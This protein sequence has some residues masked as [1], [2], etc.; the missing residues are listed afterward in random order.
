MPSGQ[1]ETFRSSLSCSVVA[2][3]STGRQTAIN[4]EWQLTSILYLHRVCTK[5]VMFNERKCIIPLQL[6]CGMRLNY[7]LLFPCK[8][9]V[10]G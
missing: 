10:K 9:E 8:K 2:L 6:E 7:L 1:E 5:L 4:E 3:Q